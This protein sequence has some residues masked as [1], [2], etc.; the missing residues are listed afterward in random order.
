MAF[1]SIAWA[2]RRRVCAA[3]IRNV[4]IRYG[5]VVSSKDLFGN[6]SG[7]V[8]EVW[9]SVRVADLQIAQQLMARTEWQFRLVSAD[10]LHDVGLSQLQYLRVVGKETHGMQRC[11]RFRF[12]MIEL[13]ARRLCEKRKSISVNI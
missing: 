11:E 8:N 13:L 3:G 12:G 10:F 9:S 6:E 1:V 5:F 2:K 4:F 7:S